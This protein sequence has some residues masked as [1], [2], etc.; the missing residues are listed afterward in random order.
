M[1][2]HVLVWIAGAALAYPVVS[3]MVRFLPRCRLR[4]RPHGPAAESA[5]SRR[6]MNGAPAP[7]IHSLFTL[8]SYFLRR[9]CGIL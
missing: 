7:Q 2:R 1:D 4:C 6:P 5:H 9:G 8:R 3:P